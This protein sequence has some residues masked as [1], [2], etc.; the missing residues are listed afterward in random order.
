MRYVSATTNFEPRNVIVSGN[1][2]LSPESIQSAALDGFQGNLVNMD[3]AEIEARVKSLPYVKTCRIARVMPDT[4]NVSIEERV[5]SAALVVDNHMFAVD[6][7]GVVLE[8]LKEPE[9]F[10]GP[11][12]TNVPDLG[13]V[14]PGTVIDKQPFIDALTVW[15]SFSKNDISER[16]EV[17]ELSVEQHGTIEMV[18]EELPYSILWAHDEIEQQVL[19]LSLLWNEEGSHNLGCSEYLDLRFGKDIACR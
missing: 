16:V 1:R 12:I 14:E 8:E 5:P 17:S 4:L 7:E 11:L 2:Y 9:T 13:L 3:T 10:A 18:C 6:A 19:Y 15:E